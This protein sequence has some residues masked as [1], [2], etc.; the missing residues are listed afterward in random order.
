M[1]TLRS[2]SLLA[3]ALVGLAA[4]SS[5]SEKSESST[6]GAFSQSNGSMNADGS[7]KEDLRFD[8]MLQVVASSPFGSELTKG[9]PI[10][11]LAIT[12]EALQGFGEDQALDPQQIQ[13][14]VGIHLIPGDFDAEN[15]ARQT[16]VTTLGGQRLTVH[17]WNGRLELQ[18]E[19]ELG[20]RSEPVE[21]LE[22]DLTYGPLRIHVLERPLE[23]NGQTLGQMLENSGS[24]SRLLTA[25]EAAGLSPI[26]DGQGPFTIFAPSDA[27]MRQLEP[28][29]V[30]AL[31]NPANRP[32][33]VQILQRHVI[34]G[35]FYSDDFHVTELR[36]ANNQTLELSWS[37]GEFKVNGAS[38]IATDFEGTNG[39][40]H[41]VD[42]LF[43]N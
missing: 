39:V 26:L 33:L 1:N 29:I 24:F 22:T 5:T 2:H 30:K 23:A 6:G 32:Q 34:P 14:M 36:T 20:R 43:Y 21:L 17:D 3:C 11:V 4:C 7:F 9:Q 41:V 42:R 19:G 18:S 10:T 37:K 16:F 28:K 13:S 40:M 12:D 27:S 15:L 38:F 8:A 25:I 35:R 31:M